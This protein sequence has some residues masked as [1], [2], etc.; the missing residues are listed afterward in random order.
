MWIWLIMLG[1]VI[2]IR[3]LIPD[4]LGEKKKNLIFL[5]L[6][7]GIVVFFSGSRCPYWTSSTDLNIYFNC[8]K[9]AIVMPLSEMQ[10]L[11]RF[12][13]GYLILNKVLA[14][15]VPWEYFIIFFESAFCTGVVFWYFYRNSK[16]I[17]MS[18]ILYICV[19]PWSFFLTGFRQGFSICLCLIAFELMKKRT[20]GRDLISLGLILL[21]Y[22]F[23]TTA[24]VFL[25]VFL[26][27]Y[28]QMSKK[29]VIMTGIISV[30][31]I[32]SARSIL[33]W[34][35]GIA[36]KEYV[37]YYQGNALGGLVPIVIYSMSLF[38]CYIIWNEEH[39]SIDEMN[40]EIV[41]LMIGL[42]IYVTRYQ[43][44]VFER[45]SYYFTPVASVVL[46]NAVS[47]QKN[48]V[49]R[50][51]MVILCLFFCGVLYAY[52][53]V[54]ENNIYHFFWEYWERVIYL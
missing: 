37:S 5:T 39:S 48:K 28:I 35:N 21:A 42:C 16:N 43:V 7:F 24:I 34:M 38:F 9:N 2:G 41:M 54:S 23:H 46:A 45:I 18:V 30:I 51:L 52:R 40:F 36:E 3:M 10:E 12:E 32:A 6:A 25:S 29:T 19:G 26:I 31:G 22:S 53:M 33:G 14:W 8:Y 11:Y 47:M 49:N 4:E 20:I 17:V 50:N 44:T 13:D 1:L 27:R 15:L